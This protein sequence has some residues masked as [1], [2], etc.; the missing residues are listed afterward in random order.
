MSSEEEATDTSH[1]QVIKISQTFNVNW[2]YNPHMLNRQRANMESRFGCFVPLIEYLCQHLKCENSKSLGER[3]LNLS[4]EEYRQ[5]VE[6]LQT[7]NLSTN[8]LYPSARNFKL[9]CNGLTHDS[10]RHVFA[11]GGYRNKTVRDHYLEHHQIDLLYPELP[12]LYQY[13]GIIKHRRGFNH[14]PELSGIF[15]KSLSEADMFHL[16]HKY[17]YPLEVVVVQLN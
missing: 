16:H 13:G 8:H 10:A 15:K 1:T 11:Y 3:M 4:M 5:L 9:F 2:S 7:L 17:Y 12:C 14:T 6:H